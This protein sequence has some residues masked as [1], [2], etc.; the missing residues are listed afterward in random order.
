MVLWSNEKHFQ[1]P[2]TL[3]KNRNTE[4][5]DSTRDFRSVSLDIGFGFL[6]KVNVRRNE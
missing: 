1:S 2:T 6:L 3:D 5:T 4:R